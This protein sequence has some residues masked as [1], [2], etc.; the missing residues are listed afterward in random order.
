MT[1]IF[2]RWEKINGTKFIQPPIPSTTAL[3]PL[4]E[5]KKYSFSYKE[6]QKPRSNQP[7]ETI[8][9]KIRKR[10]EENLGRKQT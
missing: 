3:P 10:N 7:N 1:S 9:I 5:T 2:F 6:K 8:P 4:K